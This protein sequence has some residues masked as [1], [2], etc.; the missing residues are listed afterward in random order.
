LGF[1]ILNVGLVQLSG[2]GDKKDGPRPKVLF[3]VMIL[4]PWPHGIALANVD[5]FSVAL[6]A[7]PQ[8]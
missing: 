2:T 3:G 4:Q 7:W 5:G 1:E 8:Q 6:F